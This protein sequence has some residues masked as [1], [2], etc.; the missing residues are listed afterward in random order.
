MTVLAHAGHWLIQLVYLVP[1]LV[2]VVVIVVGRF[3]D[4]DGR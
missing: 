4:R 1:L 3:R 2:L